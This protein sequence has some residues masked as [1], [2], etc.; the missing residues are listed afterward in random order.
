MLFF[1]FARDLSKFT[2]P[3]VLTCCSP[4]IQ[5][6]LIDSSHEKFR[7]LYLKALSGA[8]DIKKLDYIVVR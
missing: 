3:L 6:A 1:N 4:G 2:C 8:V 5:T 7:D